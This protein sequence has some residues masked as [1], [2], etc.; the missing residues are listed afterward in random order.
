MGVKGKK[1][2]GSG[3]IGF[4]QWN[5]DAT[6]FFHSILREGMEFATKEYSAVAY[7][8]QGGDPT[9]FRVTLPIGIN[10]D[11]NPAWMMS[12]TELVDDFIRDRVVDDG[13][14]DDDIDTAKALRDHLRVLTDRLDRHIPKG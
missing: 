12:V 14:L 8:N 9:S 2:E 1:V 7:F 6:E 3:R 4:D 13:Q 11:E 10:D 5:L